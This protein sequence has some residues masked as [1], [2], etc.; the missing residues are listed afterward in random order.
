MKRVLILLLDFTLS[1][2]QARMISS[3][4]DFHTTMRIKPR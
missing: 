1:P 4:H 3:L 2:L